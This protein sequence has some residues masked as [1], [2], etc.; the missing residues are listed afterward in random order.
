M[1]TSS[2]RRAAW[3]LCGLLCATVLLCVSLAWGGTASAQTSYPTKSNYFCPADVALLGLSWTRR[4]PYNGWLGVASTSNMEE[5]KDVQIYDPRTLSDGG[6]SWAFQAQDGSFV[7][8]MYVSADKNSVSFGSCRPYPDSW[9]V[10]S[11]V[12]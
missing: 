8:R 5:S 4:M 7:C 6:T 11:C 10:G 1:I 9:A 12:Y 2:R 3:A